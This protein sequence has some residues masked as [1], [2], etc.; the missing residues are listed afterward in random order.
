MVFLLAAFLSG[1]PPFASCCY[2][3]VH[4]VKMHLSRILI[5]TFRKF[6]NFHKE[7]A[8]KWNNAHM[9]NRNKPIYSPS[10]FGLHSAKRLKQQS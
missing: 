3:T 4:I 1:M 2:N 9:H 8:E 5:I 7:E 10:V 6:R